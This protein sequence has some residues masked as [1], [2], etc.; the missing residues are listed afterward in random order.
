MDGPPGAKDWRSPRLRATGLLLDRTSHRERFRHR[1]GS[2]TRREHRKSEI[3]KLQCK[4][5]ENLLRQNGRIQFDVGRSYAGG[6]IRNPQVPFCSSA[7]PFSGLGAVISF[8]L[9]LRTVTPPLPLTV[10]FVSNL[11]IVA[12][13]RSRSLY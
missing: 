7:S 12:Y 6:T 5:S 4:T 13:H 2:R 8:C 3:L 10:G 9:T 1:H 11:H